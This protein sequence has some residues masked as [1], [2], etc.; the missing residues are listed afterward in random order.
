[1]QVS[2]QPALAKASSYKQGVVFQ[3]M[4]SLAADYPHNAPGCERALCDGHVPSSWISEPHF[5]VSS[6]PQEQF[7]SSLEINIEQ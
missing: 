4:V 5:K 6:L 2:G 3:R 1:M 7:P